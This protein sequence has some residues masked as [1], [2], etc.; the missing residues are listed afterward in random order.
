[1]KMTLP[2]GGLCCGAEA[3]QVVIQRFNQTVVCSTRAMHGFKIW[4]QHFLPR[5]SI[6]NGRMHVVGEFWRFR[7]R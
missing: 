1:M 2:N 5:N 6:G 4:R 3:T 7:S